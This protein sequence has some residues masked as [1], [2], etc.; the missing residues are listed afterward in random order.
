MEKL[1]VCMLAGNCENTLDI[2]IESVRYAD[3]IVI[4]YDTTSLDRTQ[5]ILNVW[6]EELSEKLTILLRPYDH[7]ID[8]KYSN[9]DARMFYLDFLKKNY[10]NDFCLVID[11]DECVDDLTKIREWINKFGIIMNTY[12]CCNIQ[13]RHFIGDLGHED[14]T[15]PEHF[16][17][18]RLF[19]IDNSLVYPSGEHPVL[20]ST[21]EFKEYNIKPTVIWH[22][23]YIPNIWDIKKRYDNHMNKSEI[24][25]K[26]FLRQWYYAHLFGKYPKKEINIIDI[27][28]IILKKFGIDR[29]MFYFQNRNVD[30]K[31]FIMCRNWYDYFSNKNKPLNIIEFGCG[32]AP[33]GFAFNFIADDINYTG[34]ELSQYAV[35]NAFVKIK[36]GDITSYNAGRSYDLVICSDVLEH[37]NDEQL[38][39]A[40]IN[41]CQHGD[42]FIFSLPFDKDDELNIPVDPN[43]YNDS[44]H[45]QFKS[46]REWIKLFNENGITIT[47][48]P[49]KWLFGNQL[50][51]GERK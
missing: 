7:S 11:A 5:S 35:D 45:K 14:S 29:D 46:K 6:Q 50:L 20:Q 28:E 15:R 31:H 39:Q 13:M 48:P 37:L 18:G 36:Q 34:V 3:K 1:I 44:T 30:V 49:K 23:G 24:H 26:E 10:K 51:I 47:E 40:I 16:V 25:T 38:N 12:P 22:L 32:K 41:I 33:F 2:A 21:K 9:S 8:N 19:K 43:L 27:P 17:Q 42:N 4:V